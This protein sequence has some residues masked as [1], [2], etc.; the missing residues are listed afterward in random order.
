MT[1]RARRPRGGPVPVR[2][3]GSWASPRPCEPRRR[4]G[5]VPGRLPPP[6]RPGQRADGGRARHLPLWRAQSLRSHPQGL[7][8]ASRRGAHRCRVRGGAAA[9]PAVP[10]VVSRTTATRSN[11]PSSSR[12][13]SSST[14]SGAR[15]PIVPVLCGPFGGTGWGDVQRPKTTPESPSSS[16]PC[17]GS[18]RGAARLFVLG[19]DMTHVGRRYG[20]QLQARGRGGCAARRRAR[21][22]HPHGAPTAGDAAGFWSRVAFAGDPSTGAGPRLSIPS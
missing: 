4:L 14:C 19:V 7:R 22:P 3:G 12:S 15:V 8:H 9:K 16:R 10:P 6:G 13:S 2:R 11:I 5:F 18:R 21:R 17:A 1:A 20:D